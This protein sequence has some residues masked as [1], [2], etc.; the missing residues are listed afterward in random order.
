[1]GTHTVNSPFLRSGCPTAI[2]PTRGVTEEERTPSSLSFWGPH[3]LDPVTFEPVF[4]D[5]QRRVGRAL[6]WREQCERRKDGLATASAEFGQ[7][8]WAPWEAA[9]VLS[10]KRYRR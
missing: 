9:V 5:G 2:C 7:E 6:E 4:K 1:M 3:L 10:A 8:P